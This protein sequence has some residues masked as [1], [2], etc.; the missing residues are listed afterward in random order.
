MTQLIALAFG[1]RPFLLADAPDWAASERL[2]V[3]AAPDRAEELAP[4]TTASQRE[5]FRDR[6]RQ[7]VR[8][9]LTDRF[10]LV[11]RT[12]RRPMPVYQLVLAKGGHKMTAATAQDTRRMETNSRMLRG[13]AVDMQMVADALAGILSRP[14]LDETNLEGPFNLSIQFADQN[15]Q[16]TPETIDALA[17]APTLFTAIAEQLGL[18]LESGRAPTPVFVVER[19]TRPTE[20]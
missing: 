16:A 13:T 20:N 6:V 8:T 2:D 19:I 15:M 14:V 7:R 11:I 12:E 10:G 3:V 17:P 18:R 4:A 9:L 5:F 1:V